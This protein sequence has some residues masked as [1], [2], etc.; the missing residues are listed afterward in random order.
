MAARGRRAKRPKGEKPSRCCPAVRVN[1]WWRRVAGTFY[2]ARRETK[3]QGPHVASKERGR[4]TET[5]ARGVQSSS[6]QQIMCGV[7]AGPQAG[8]GQDTSRWAGLGGA[9]G[10]SRRHTRQLTAWITH[11]GRRYMQIPARPGHKGTKGPLPGPTACPPACPPACTA[12]RV[13]TGASTPPSPGRSGRRKWVPT[14][15]G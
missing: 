5:G 1:D 12:P 9:K 14:R 8:D 11:R 2:C 7:R 6:M 13:R 4:R 3:Y 10:G 15:L